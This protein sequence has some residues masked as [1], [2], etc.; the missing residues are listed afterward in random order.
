M[1][2]VFVSVGSNIDRQK[3]VQ[4]AL[5]ELKSHFGQLSC[6]S[7]YETEAVGFAGDDFFNMVVA[8]DTDLAPEVVNETLKDIEQAHGRQ[9]GEKKFAAR[10]LDLDLLLYGGAVLERPGLHVPRD[11]IE[12][13]AFVLQPLAEMAPELVYPGRS[14]SF[15]AMWQSAVASGAMQAAPVAAW[16]PEA[17][18]N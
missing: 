3:H 8:F 7:V 13:Y 15:E 18:G 4:A 5:N 1:T 11:E 12:H 10:T 2:R 9:R 16:T 6:S 17:C 14:Q